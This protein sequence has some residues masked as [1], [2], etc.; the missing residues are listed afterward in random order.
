MGARQLRTHCLELG[1]INLLLLFAAPVHAQTEAADLYKAKCAVC[2]SIDGKGDTAAGRK[3]GAR[4]FGSPEVQRETDQELLEIT[5]KGKNKMPG[6]EKSLKESQMKDLVAYIR[7][8]GK[9]K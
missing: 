8:L 7:E 6:Y 9:K 2:H 1:A 3:L 5:A 4:D